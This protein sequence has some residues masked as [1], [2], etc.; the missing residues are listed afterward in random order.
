MEPPQWEDVLGGG[1]LWLRRAASPGPDDEGA[2]P[3]D[4]Q[5]VVLRVACRVLE[6]DQ[7]EGGVVLTAQRVHLGGAIYAS[8]DR[9]RVKVAEDELPT[10]LDL[11]V[12]LLPGAGSS[13][14]FRMVARLAFGAFGLPAS[15]KEHATDATIASNDHAH[16]SSSGCSIMLHAH[17]AIP[18]H[19]NVEF[20]VDLLSVGAPNPPVESLN[21]SQR[22]RA[23]KR[24]VS[25][26]NAAFRRGDVSRAQALFSRGLRF[27]QPTGPHV[28]A[29][30]VTEDD[31]AGLFACYVRTGCNL[32]VAYAKTGQPDKEVCKLCRSVLSVQEGKASLKAR[33]QL[34]RALMRMTE[35]DEAKACFETVLKM[36]DSK[37]EKATEKELAKLARHVAK[38]RRKERAMFSGANVVA[39][40][41]R[42]QPT[43]TEG[44]TAGVRKRAQSSSSKDGSDCGVKTVPQIEVD[45]EDDQPVSEVCRRGTCVAKWIAA[46]IASILLIL[47]LLMHS[48]VQASL[49]TRV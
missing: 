41:A 7:E 1:S 31:I 24:K 15:Q 40:L 9:L 20:T 34:G 8:A 29:D 37:T 17:T 49:A 48:S 46:V 43:P 16:T 18:P 21:I 32:A 26:G 44:D 45:A 6:P 39:A 12:R 27:V 14:T 13:A 11:G 25:L 3:L 5:E 2:R 10:G 30:D 19:T 38:Y 4:G 22:V 47:T 28:H 42:P 33:F 35:Y 23:A 36:A